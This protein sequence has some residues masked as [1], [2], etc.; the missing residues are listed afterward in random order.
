MKLFLI[1][2]AIVAVT[3]FFFIKQDIS[4]GSVAVNVS[5][6]NESDKEPE[7]IPEISV[8]VSILPE[9]IIQGELV[10][11]T[12]N[13]TQA[14]KSITFEGKR[15]DVFNNEGKLQALIGIDLRKI[16][17]KYPLVVIL[18]DGTV[19]KKDITV[20][21]RV[22]VKEKFKIP[23]KLGGDTPESEKNLISTLIQEGVIINSIPTGDKKLWE[24]KFRY[25]T[26]VPIVTD[27]YGYSRLTGA[28]TIA[29]KGTDFRALVG[30]PLY[31]MNTGTVRYTR[32]LRNYGHTIVLDHG[33][34][35]QT[36]YMHLSEVLVK[37]GDGVVKGEL[38]AKSG[39]TGYV[40][41]PH[42]H[43]SIKIDHIS[44]DPMKFMELLGSI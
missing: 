22:V 43:L 20:G 16:S 27:V 4:P 28:S 2:I 13:G 9:R 31:A 6:V 21:E 12:I 3:G 15:L 32:Y 38:I 24:G 33:L 41:G 25:P 7:Q 35:L 8:S 42:L 26:E 29:H 44:I 10:L 11:V 34:G 5:E 40:F 23:E 14:V 37:N 1:V 30:T 17:G 39:D 18:V 36:I 19:I